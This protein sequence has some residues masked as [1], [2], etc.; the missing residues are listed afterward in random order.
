MVVEIERCSWIE[1]G[2]HS[3]EC[4]VH[5]VAG[6]GWGDGGDG[7]VNSKLRSGPVE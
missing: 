5:S 3:E 2:L 6:W 7:I 4:S 1:K